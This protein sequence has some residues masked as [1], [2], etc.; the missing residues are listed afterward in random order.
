MT[1]DRVIGLNNGIP[2]HYSEDFKRFK[3]MTL[4]SSIIM[5]R[6]TWESIGN[7]PL[8]KRRNIV[9]SRRT[10]EGVE[11]YP[12][13]KLALQACSEEKSVWLIGGGQIYAQGLAYCTHLDITLVPDIID[14]D[15]AIFFPEINSVHWQAGLTQTLPEDPRLQT[16]SYTRRS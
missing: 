12:S 10:V 5:G 3:R 2:W 15:N 7:K 6:K 11:H 8:P 4:N 14:T 16:R 9:I 13:I 1:Q